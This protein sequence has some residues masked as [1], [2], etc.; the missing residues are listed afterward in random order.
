M[1]CGE[2]DCWWYGIE[3]VLFEQGHVPEGRPLVRAGRR[4]LD[5]SS[6]EKV[7]LDC[8]WIRIKNLDFAQRI[9]ID[10]QVINH[11]NIWMLHYGRFIP[12]GEPP[13]CIVQF[14]RLVHQCSSLTT[15]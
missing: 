13:H 7:N 12:R 6:S 9:F 8:D 2:R 5:A 3:M 10:I 11:A 1:V 4:V 15:L 14:T